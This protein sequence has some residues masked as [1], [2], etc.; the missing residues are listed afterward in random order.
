MKKNKLFLFSIIGL[1]LFAITC[2]TSNSGDESG[3]GSDEHPSRVTTKFLN[4]DDTVLYANTI[5][6]GGNA[7]YEG[8]KPKRPSS[9]TTFYSFS[10]WDKSL[11]NIIVDTTFHAQYSETTRKYN[12]SFI[13]YDDEVLETQN[14][15]YDSMPIYGGRTPTRPSSDQYSYTFSNWSPEITKVSSDAVYKAEYLSTTNKYTVTWV[16]DGAVTTEEYEYGEIP[17]FKG[18]TEKARTAEYSYTFTGWE[19]NIES[20]SSDVTYT[21]QY[22]SSRNFYTIT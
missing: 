7:V 22:S 21:A 5:P 4:Y 10:G 18:S 16:V 3:G 1:S 13:N 15:E 2:C 12:I 11:E 20:V 19:P 17:T 9:N 6:Y 14:L 8:E